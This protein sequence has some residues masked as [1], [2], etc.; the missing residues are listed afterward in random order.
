MLDDK[1]AKAA[2]EARRAYDASLG[3]NLPPW[4]EAE[5]WLVR[6]YRATVAWM[7]NHPGATV[8]EA[9]EARLEAVFNA[10][11]TR[12]P[13]IDATAKT[14]PALVPWDELPAEQRMRDAIGVAVIA[15]L[16]AKE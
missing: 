11:W 4:E 5:D 14:H 16:L 10:G 15:A 6:S 13:T 1:I 9:H 12:G 7:R 2:Y 8:Q 3:I